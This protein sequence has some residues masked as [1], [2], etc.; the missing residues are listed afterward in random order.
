MAPGV[1]KRISVTSPASIDS[2]YKQL[3]TVSSIDQSGSNRVLYFCKNLHSSYHGSL[4]HT[5][6]KNKEIIYDFVGISHKTMSCSTTGRRGVSKDRDTVVKFPSA[7]Y[8]RH[9]ERG[10]QKNGH[11]GGV[12]VLESHLTDYLL[13]FGTKEDKF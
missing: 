5:D 12:D 8:F 6:I 7:A 4:D 9:F 1:Q 10:F 11:R 13:R 3:H 2:E